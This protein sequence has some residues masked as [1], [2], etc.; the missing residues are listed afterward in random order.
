MWF[1][2]QISTSFSWLWIRLMPVMSWNIRSIGWLVTLKIQ[3]SHVTYNGAFDSGQIACHIL[4]WN[5]LGIWTGYSSHSKAQ[6]ISPLVQFNPFLVMLIVSGLLR[7]RG[8]EHCCLRQKWCQ[9]ITTNS[10]G[11]C[12]IAQNFGIGIM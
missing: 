8:C 7:F 11:L 4:D 12:L 9:F 3:S 1:V 5:C 6:T 2:W 10:V